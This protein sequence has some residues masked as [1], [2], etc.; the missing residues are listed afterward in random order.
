MKYFI[1]AILIATSS[2]LR[3]AEVLH[4]RYPV[5]YTYV[6]EQGDSDPVCKHMTGVFN[7]RFKTP[8]DGGHLDTSP[9]ITIFGIPYD[10]VFE[11]M[12][13]VEHDPRKTFAM[14]LS[15]FPSSEEFEALHWLEGRVTSP[16]TRGIYPALIVQWTP[17]DGSNPF[18]IVKTTFMDKMTTNEGWGQSDGGF[19]TLEFISD[20][21]FKPT[22]PILESFITH[23][24]AWQSGSTRSLGR[25]TA[26]Q[27]RPF[28]FR[29]HLYIAAYQSAWR[30]KAPS[31]EQA[32]L[33]PDEEFMSVLRLLPE[34]I[35]GKY[36]DIAKTEVV[37]RIRMLMQHTTSKGA[38]ST[39]GVRDI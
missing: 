34:S 32:R 24:P 20:P 37:C 21:D 30:E 10:K 27:L 19:D 31:Y 3:A 15:R 6:L 18:W 23:H 12:P 4:S 17:K 22:V 35:P 2:I 28:V 16:D 13:G 8:W 25:E 39:K 33:Y 26:R 11:R 1:F 36:V 9:G 7:A 38:K 29:E 14:M 5:R